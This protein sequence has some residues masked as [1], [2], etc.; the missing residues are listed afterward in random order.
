MTAIC[1]L[2]HTWVTKHMYQETDTT[3]YQWRHD[4]F[5]TNNV[6]HRYKIA[7]VCV[8]ICKYTPRETV[9]RISWHWHGCIWLF[10]VSS[11]VTVQIA[12]GVANYWCISMCFIRMS[13]R[14]NCSWH[15][16]HLCG[17][18]PVCTTMCLLRWPRSVNLFWHISQLCGLS[19]VCV[20][21]CL[22]RRL[23]RVNCL[24]HI[25]HL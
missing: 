6:L 2:T 8:N 21:R 5:S 7:K 11:C 3:L 17:L 13:R 22:L 15:T 19:P 20:S 12:N 4:K 25:S 9:C 18:S 14:V 23:A 24:W 1:C 16:T 10:H